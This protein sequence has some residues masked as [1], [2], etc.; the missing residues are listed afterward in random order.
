MN[1]IRTCEHCAHH[2]TCFARLSMATMI[3]EF[4][5]LALNADE[6]RTCEATHGAEELYRALCGACPQYT[7]RA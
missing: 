4:R 6:A 5:L 2:L 3:Y 7:A 1:E